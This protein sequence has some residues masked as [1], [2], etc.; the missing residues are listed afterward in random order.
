MLHLTDA[1]CRRLIAFAPE[2]IG[3][4]ISIAKVRRKQSVDL[5]SYYDESIPKIDEEKDN[6]LH[7]Y[8]LLMDLS[9]P[10]DHKNKQPE[11]PG[12][13][14]KAPGSPN[15][16]PG[17]QAKKKFSS[18]FAGDGK[19]QTDG[20]G[21]SSAAAQ[22]ATATSPISSPMAKP[23]RLSFAQQQTKVVQ[24]H[25]WFALAA[26][27]GDESAGKHRDRLATKMTPAQLAEA[28]RLAREWRPKPGR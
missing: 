20:A 6:K 25:M 21:S 17:S 7:L 24:A 22:I 1:N 4:L 19:G 12:S 26:A 11:A 28:Q 13:P 16:A 18:S 27:Q 23:L 8:A 3:E 2:L 10:K 15:K 14:N 5:Y 9:E